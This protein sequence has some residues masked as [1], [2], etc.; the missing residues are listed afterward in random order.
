MTTWQ[1]RVQPVVTATMR[2]KA[3]PGFVI[4]AA[5]GI[6]PTEF[7]VAGADA[8]GVA[9]ETGSLFP[10]ASLTKLATALAVLRLAATGALAIDDPLAAH[11]PDAR[12]AG[13]GVTLRMLLSH[14]SG[15]PGD[16]APARRPTPRSWTGRPWRAPAWRRHCRDR[17]GAESPTAI[18]E[19]GCSL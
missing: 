8:G 12:C 17:R 4:A 18:Q 11:L 19:R 13:E 14:T 9:L 15:L 5:R 2:E 7:L 1:S 10:V 6:R 3:V 16:L